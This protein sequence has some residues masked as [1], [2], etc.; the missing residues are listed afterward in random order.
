ME[1]ERT[2]HAAGAVLLAWSAG[3]INK[4]YR[5]INKSQQASPNIR[6]SPTG[7]PDVYPNSPTSTDAVR[8]SGRRSPAQSGAVRLS[9]RSRTQPDAA[10]RPMQRRIARRSRAEVSPPRTVRRSGLLASHGGVRIGACTLR[11]LGVSV[12]QG[13]EAGLHSHTRIR[14]PHHHVCRDA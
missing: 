12:S 7:L 14:D 10:T 1:A 9:P 2:Y 4:V 8:R 11:S 3:S 5:S 13:L 6:R